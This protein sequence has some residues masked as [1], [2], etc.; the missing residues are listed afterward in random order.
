MEKALVEPSL[1]RHEEPKLG[2][3]D[4]WMNLSL[5]P[6]LNTKKT[7]NRRSLE[8]QAAIKKLVVDSVTAALEAQA[9]T[10]ASTSNPNRNTRPTGT[11]AYAPTKGAVDIKPNQNHLGL[12]ESLLTT[13]ISNV[14]SPKTG[15]IAPESGS[16][17]LRDYSKLQSTLRCKYQLIIMKS[18]DDRENLQQL[19]TTI[20]AQQNYVTLTIQHNKTEGQEAVIAYVPLQL[21]TVGC[22][23]DLGI[24]PLELDLMPIKL[25]SFDV[26]VGMD[27]LSKYH[28]RIICDEKIVHIPINGETLIILV[29]IAQLMKKKSNEK[30]LEDIP[31]VREFLEVFLKITGL[32]PVRK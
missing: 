26:I 23:S 8:W 22:N 15:T 28:A 25:S 27:W 24:Q 16:C 31:V 4:H 3:S 1:E 21:R 29:F 32:P 20:T 9:A 2:N 17:H 18:L 5:G 11:L 7:K 14:L 30:R 10:M 19:T 12:S 13:K 6:A